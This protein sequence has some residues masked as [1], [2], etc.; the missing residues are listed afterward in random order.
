MHNVFWLIPGKLAGRP[1]PDLM[2]W[3]AAQLRAGGIDVVLSVNDG[4]LVEP[5][6]LEDHGIAYACIPF[7]ANAPPIPGDMEIC[8]DAL[9]KAFAFVKEAIDA[10]KTLMIHCLSGKDRTGLVM[11]YFLMQTKGLTI[12]E[13]I[14]EVRRV[15]PIALSAAGWEEFGREILRRV[16]E[17][18][19]ESR[20]S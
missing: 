7:S 3:D 12:D 10:G 20:Q 15:R 2:P 5:D 1:G 14:R 19:Q 4:F 13:A 9:P 8:L 18:Q 11:S 6:T 17:N 16:G